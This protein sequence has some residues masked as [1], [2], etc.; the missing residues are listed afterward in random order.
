MSESEGERE[1]VCEREKEIERGDER[2]E[3]RERERERESMCVRERR[4]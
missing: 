3:E 1:Y 4:R 2:R